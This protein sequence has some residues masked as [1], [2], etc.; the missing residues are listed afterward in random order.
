MWT[1]QIL[2]ESKIEEIHKGM[3]K[4]SELSYRD[5]QARA[6]E[7]GIAANKKREVL[8]EAILEAE[9]SNTEDVIETQVES[10]VVE[11]PVVTVEVTETVTISEEVVSEQPQVESTSEIAAPQDE[12]ALNVS[13]EY[14][15]S[16]AEEKNAVVEEQEEE[17]EQEFYECDTGD[18]VDAFEGMQLRGIPNPAGVKTVFALE[19]VSSEPTRIDW[20]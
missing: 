4:Y 11:T 9:K 15:D 1:T 2:L 10:E 17:E 14:F 7:L 18:L 3:E 19:E 5:I 6:K 8:I 13:L 20:G 16:L 12:N